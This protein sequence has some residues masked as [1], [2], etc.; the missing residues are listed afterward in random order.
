[1]S[2]PTPD[3]SY[4]HEGLRPLAVPI[5]SVEGLTGNPR[6][7]SV[8]AVAASLKTFQQRKPIIARKREGQKPEVVAGNHTLMA[9]LENGW[10][11]IAVLIVDDDERT[12]KA[13]ALADNRTSDLGDTDEELLDAMLAEF[14]ADLDLPPD[15]GFGDLMRSLEWDGGPKE[16]KKP[17]A[18]QPGPVT[19][20]GGVTGRFEVIVECDDEEHQRLTMKALADQGYRTKG[21][22]V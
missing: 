4:I 19:R 15:E 7:G 13:F 1:M 16:K 17:P 14:K 18:R 12:G 22:I 2:K 11:H 8:P 9:A 21:K 3:L 20:A 10:S 6:R 5:D